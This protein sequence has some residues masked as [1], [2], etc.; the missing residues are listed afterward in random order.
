MARRKN[1]LMVVADQWRGQDLGCLGAAHAVTPNLD[2]LAAEGVTFTAHHGQATPCSP[3]R[4]SLLTGL[5]QMNHRVAGNGTP[6]DARHTTLAQQ[7]R[8]VGHDPVLFGYTDITADPRGLDPADPR[9][10][11]YEG[12]LPGLTPGLMLI[13]NPRPWIARL[14]TLGYPADLTIDTVYAP[15][16]SVPVPPGRGRSFAPT[17]FPAEQSETAFLTDAAL[18]HLSTQDQPWFVMLCY[19][20]PHPPLIAPAPFHALVDPADVPAPVRAASAQQEAAQHPYIDALLRT[21]QFAEMVPGAPGLVAE[22]SDLD[23]RQMRAT[24]YGLMAHVDQQLGRIIAWL[25]D[26]GQYDDT[27][28][29]FTSDHAEE[30]GDHYTCNKSSYFDESVHVPLILRDPDAPR[31]GAR[32]DAFTEAVDVMPT[33]LD[34]L[35][36]D[37]PETL[38]GASLL[39]FLRQGEPAGWRQQTFWEKDFRDPVALTAERHFGL[40]PD[41]CSYAV[42]RDRDWKYVHFAGMPPA[43][44]DLRNDPGELVN[45]AGDP[46]LA[47]VMLDYAQR[48]LS[49]RM[50][51]ADRT[52]VNHMATDRGMMQWRGPR[53]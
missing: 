52:L 51:H 18:E 13:E 29:V 17:V 46:L 11:T 45:R 36:I 3:A 48:L 40:T 16:P 24:Y 15:D 6:L 53:R 38:D 44:Y 35:G 27:L 8:R 22:A 4:A 34:W 5:Y 2:A 14:K 47:G 19:L 42:I 33:I 23:L 1:V 20:R 39:P 30:L 12:L 43:F 37:P 9:L 31:R 28:I 50:V 21:R 32:V 41:Q 7:V 49:H 25:K 26:T 10:F